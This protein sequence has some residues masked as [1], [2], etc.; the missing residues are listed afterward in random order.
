MSFEWKEPSE[1]EKERMEMRSLLNSYHSGDASMAWLLILILYEV[2]RLVRRLA[3]SDCV[4]GSD[5]N[6]GA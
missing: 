6:G 3:P 1:L 4:G 5:A 2:K